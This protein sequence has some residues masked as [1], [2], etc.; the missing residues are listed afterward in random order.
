MYHVCIMYHDVV[1][2]CM[3]PLYVSLHI[4]YIEVSFCAIVLSLFPFHN[5]KL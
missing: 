2:L 5:F 4:L 3:S 1:K